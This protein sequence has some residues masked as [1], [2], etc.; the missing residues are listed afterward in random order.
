MIGWLYVLFVY[1]LNAVIA[2]GVTVAEA[3]D[4]GGTQSI[5]QFITLRDLAT[6]PGQSYVVGIVS[7]ALKRLMPVHSDGLNRALMTVGAIVVNFIAA[8]S[9]APE[10]P[11][12]RLLM[13]T[14]IMMSILN[15]T[16]IAVAAMKSIEFV[17]ERVQ[18]E[19]SRDLA[20]G[21]VQVRTEVTAGR[22]PAAGTQA[23]EPS[24]L[25]SIATDPDPNKDPK[26]R[27]AP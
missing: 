9:L 5:S 14:L 8:L 23:P 15:G 21:G 11:E 10:F 12:T 19:M 27:D 1:G 3:Q 6:F 22:R 7:E 17:V 13:A 25:A 18:R 26:R 24:P 16:A 2:V 4:A 20:A